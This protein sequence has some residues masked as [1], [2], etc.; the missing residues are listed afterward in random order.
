MSSKEK[1]LLCN[2]GSHS[3]FQFEI[4]Q[5][6][7][8]AARRTLGTAIGKCPKSKLFRGYIDLEI[9]MREFQRCR[10]LYEKFL[11]FDPENCTAWMKYSGIATNRHFSAN[12]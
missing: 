8:T 6:D 9:H 7:V 3:C 4:R 5:K 2:L 12:F 10:I 11:L 1:T